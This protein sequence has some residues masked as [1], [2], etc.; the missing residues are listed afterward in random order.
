MGDAGVV[1]VGMVDPIYNVQRL[2]GSETLALWSVEQ[3]DLVHAMCEFFCR[4]QGDAVRY[5]LSQGM[6]PFFGWVG[7][8]IC[9]PPLMGPV[10]FRDFVVR[11]DRRLSDLIH[12]AGGL[13]WVH[14]HGSVSKVLEDFIAAGI[15]CLQPLEPPPYGDLVLAEAKRRVQ[16]RLCLE[17][18]FECYEFDRF[19]PEQMRERVRQAMADAAPGGGYIVAT[20]SGPTAPMTPQAVETL[21]TFVEAVEEFGRY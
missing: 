6:G 7:P 2:I 10:D 17:G 20:A 5:C 16:G 19:T 18:N 12:D 9:V 8:E 3:R 15:D 1:I 14:C 4:R 11:Y 21:V 13:I